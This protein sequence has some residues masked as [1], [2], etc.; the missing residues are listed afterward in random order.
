MKFQFLREHHVRALAKKK[1]EI[2]LNEFVLHQDN[3]PGHAVASTQLEID[4]LRFQRLAYVPYSPDLVPMDFRVF[5][6]LKDQRW[7]LRFDSKDKLKTGT[8]RVVQQFDSK[9]YEDSFSMWVRR[10]QKCESKW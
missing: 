8:Q 10:A 3:A 2:P 9:W 1:L 5:P 7:G 4:L 6:V